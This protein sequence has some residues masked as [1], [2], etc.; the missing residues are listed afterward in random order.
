MS[1]TH[2]GKWLLLPLLLIALIAL[3]GAFAQETTAG[4]Q[5]TV[6]DPTG[7]S[8]P[9]AA[10]EVSGPALIGT[11]KI[12]TDDA[13]SYR[14]AAL[15]PGTY[16]LTVSASGFRTYKQGGIDLTVGRMPNLD[17]R[18]E[19]GAVA[20]TVEV[21]GAAPMVD[22]TQSKVAVTVEREV[23]DN[24]PKGRSFQSLIPLAPPAT[25]KT[26]TWWMV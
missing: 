1:T 14:F 7:A 13:G 15:P 18:L 9:G 8:I 6:K 11:R 21:S 3:P 16:V 5:G 23:I 10:L 22:T 2:R 17:V 4:F 25:R 24:L 12:Q 19:I 26:S 20:E